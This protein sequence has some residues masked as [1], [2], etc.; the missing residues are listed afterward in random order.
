MRGEEKEREGERGGD[1]EWER[2]RGGEDSKDMDVPHFQ[3]PKYASGCRVRVGGPY[4][5]CCYAF[6]RWVP[7]QITTWLNVCEL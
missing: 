6:S 2:R 5:L 7:S 3:I 4:I 1:R